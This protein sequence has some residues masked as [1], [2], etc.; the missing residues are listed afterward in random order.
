MKS[1][2]VMPGIH[3][4]TE[5]PFFGERKPRMGDFWDS[6]VGAIPT[7]I[8]KGTDIYLK[9][10]DAKIAQDKAD[11]AKAAAAVANATANAALAQNTIA[12]ID[13]STFIIGAAGIGIALIV[14]T[15]ALTR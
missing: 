4:P 6:I 5:Q 3:R 2:F 12:G 10:Q 11:A 13:K 15:I 1:L 9:E 7:A 8:D 14:V